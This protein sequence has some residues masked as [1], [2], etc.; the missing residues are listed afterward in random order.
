MG[1]CILIELVDSAW[2]FALDIGDAMQIVY[3]VFVIATV[4]AKINS[5][6]EDDVYL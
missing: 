4:A 3:V 2:N 6:S 5:G 1:F